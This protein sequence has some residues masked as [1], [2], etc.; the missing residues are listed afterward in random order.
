MNKTMKEHERENLKNAM[1]DYSQYFHQ[2]VYTD[3]QFNTRF[4]NKTN[5]KS[6]PYIDD[7]DEC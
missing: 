6:M 3:T 1:Q 7:E 2:I 4:P 5:K